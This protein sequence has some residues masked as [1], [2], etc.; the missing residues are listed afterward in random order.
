MRRF[1]G[2]LVVPRDPVHLLDIDRHVHRN[3]TTRRA[4]QTVGPDNVGER[5]CRVTQ[6]NDRDTGCRV[7]QRVIDVLRPTLLRFGNGAREQ[8]DLRA[9]FARG[10]QCGQCVRDAGALRDRAHPDPPR[11]AEVA[12]GHRDRGRLVASSVITHLH[13]AGPVREELHVPIA[14]QSED[15]AHIFIAQGIGDRFKDLHN[16]D[17]TPA[18][19]SAIL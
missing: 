13:L 12:V 9:S 11:G 5:G 2:R 19:S 3:R 6:L 10:N 8:Q 18:R 1:L 16:S 14:H 7:D 4:R 15:L 17:L